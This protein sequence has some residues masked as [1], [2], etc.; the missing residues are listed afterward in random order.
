MKRL[1]LYIA[2][3]LIIVSAGHLQAG[4]LNKSRTILRKTITAYRHIKNSPVGW[5]VLGYSCRKRP[6][7]Y[8]EFGSGQKTVLI[9]GGMHGDEPAATMSVIKFGK[10]LHSCP[11]LITGSR[12]VL[13]PCINPDG[14]MRGTRTNSRGVDLN[15][16]FPSS[17][18]RAEYVKSYNNPGKLPASEPE[19]VLMVNAIFNCR[20]WLI[21]QV[22]Q[23]FGNLYLSEGVPEDLYEQMSRLS[24]L[25]IEFDIGYDTPGSLGSYAAMDE[26]DIPVI[27]LELG[28][29][30]AEPDYGRINLSLLE[31]V[32]YR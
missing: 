18:W 28:P 3:L 26:I 10:Y 14:L 31:A 24:G 21:I 32:N 9:I 30:Y 23:P 22:H 17:T 25:G 12:V 13:I 5:K 2:V 11:E 15:R 1:K 7:Y 16:N 19:T 8:R 20:P 27:T 4:R 29:V 6:I